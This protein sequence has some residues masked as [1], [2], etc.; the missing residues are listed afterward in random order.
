MAE[1]SD[2]LALIQAQL[3]QAMQ[4]NKSREYVMLKLFVIS[5]NY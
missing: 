1:H 4:R 3:Q 2:A 5:S